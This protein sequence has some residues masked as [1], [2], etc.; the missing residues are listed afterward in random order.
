MLAVTEQGERGCRGWMQESLNEITGG[1][2]GNIDGR[3][4][5]NFYLQQ[6]PGECV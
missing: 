2:S 6:E 1:G 3:S 4:S 5:G